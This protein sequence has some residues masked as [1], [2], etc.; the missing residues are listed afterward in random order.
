MQE[1]AAAI[2]AI[3]TVAPDLIIFQIRPQ[4]DLARLGTANPAGDDW[5][6]AVSLRDIT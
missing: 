1:K 5:F 4:P 2:T 3:I 6:S